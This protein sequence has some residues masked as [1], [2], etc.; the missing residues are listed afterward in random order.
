M[1]GPGDVNSTGPLLNAAVAFGLGDSGPE[2][3]TR[4][5]YVFDLVSAYHNSGR[6]PGHFKKAAKTLR[7]RGRDDLADYLE[8]HAR[9]ETGH[10]GFVIKDL[11]ALGLPGK[12]L[13]EYTPQPVQPLLNL[14]DDLVVTDYPVGVIGY[15]YAFESTAN[16]K[17]EKEV[18]A[19]K[20]LLPS[21]IDCT[22][23]LRTHSALGSEATHVIELV[24]FIASLPARDRIQIMQT[25]YVTARKLGLYRDAASALSENDI[26]G[27]LNCA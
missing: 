27:L 10:D 9:E 26:S 17:G 18:A 20:K 11:N 5:R 14:F 23:F 21:G 13:V 8:K 6:T 25:A 12:S 7:Q 22:R 24:E 16:M 15:S 1:S 4:A 3:Y 2:T 19:I